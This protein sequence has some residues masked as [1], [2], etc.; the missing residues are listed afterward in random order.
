[1]VTAPVASNRERIIGAE[2]DAVGRNL[3]VGK[4]SDP[5]MEG[6]MRKPEFEVD[7]PICDDPVPAIDAALAIVNVVE[8]NQDALD[9]GQMKAS[10]QT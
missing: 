7:V 5:A 4:A 8:E 3:G 9:P 10:A 1:M 2:D 6:A